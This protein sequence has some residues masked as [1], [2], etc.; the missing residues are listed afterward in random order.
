RVYRMMIADV[1][2][3][4]AAVS[5]VARVLRDL[6]HRYMN[7]IDPTKFLMQ[8]NRHFG[9]LA[10]SSQFATAVVG[11]FYAP[12][13]MLTI[14]NA[15]HP[16]PYLYRARK[17]SWLK[18]EEEVRAEGVTNL[19]LGILDESGYESFEV[20]LEVGDIVLCHSDSLTESRCRD[21]SLLGDDRLLK[22]LESVDVSEPSHLI[23]HLLAKMSVEGAVIQDDATML[24]FQ[25]T[26]RRT[27]AKF[28]SRL[29]GQLKLVG[30][31]FTGGPVAWPEIS[32]RNIGGFFSTRLARR[33]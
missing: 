8:M 24:L 5:E 19:P 7:H 27:Q 9:Q 29:T 20:Q 26:G 10:Q 14:T 32:V 3:H 22:L 21:G 6:M 2:G 15:G 16:S 12:T 30:S 4:G 28:F 33:R 31:I 25:V 13:R 23:H 1:A 18:L 17:R 11:T